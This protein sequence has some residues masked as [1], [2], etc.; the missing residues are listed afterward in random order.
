MNKIRLGILLGVFAGIIDVTLMLIQKLPWDANFS[1]F[2]FWII[3]GFFIATSNIKFKGAIKGVIIS[4]FVLLPSAIIIGWKEP[5]S[6]IPI[7]IM[8][9]ILGSIIGHFVDRYGKN[10]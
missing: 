9:F 3:S 5:F 6:L 1:A 8:T 7:F 4:S 10:F 2:A